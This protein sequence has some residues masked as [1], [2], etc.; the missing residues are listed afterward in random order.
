MHAAAFAALA[1]GD[2]RYQLLPVPPALLAETVGALG[3]AGFVGANVTIPHKEA[4]LALADTASASARAIGA[5]N[6]LTFAADGAI[7]AENTDAPGFLAAVPAP[8]AGTT[9]MVLGAGGSAR[10]V[11]WALL[12]AGAERVSVWN[13]TPE[14]AR[15][16]ASDLGAEAVGRPVAADLLV[17]CTAA[18]LED[19]ATLDAV[20]KQLNLSNDDLSTYRYLVDLVYRDDED[21]PLLRA[22]RRRGAV[23]VS[24]L[25]VLVHQGALSLQ[26][27]TGLP[28][29]LEAMR[30]AA[31]AAGPA[32][33]GQIDSG[34]SPQAGSSPRNRGGR[35]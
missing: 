14:R 10:A 25:E 12:D 23:G 26:L 8:V 34:K 4:A 27:W 21:T 33:E 11:A 22:A 30:R 17:N 20:L 32:A 31:S 13:R 29:P 15:R 3:P 9:A 19:S 24:G 28:A 6:T 35:R 5:A 2:W 18:G 16:L 1:L 7:G